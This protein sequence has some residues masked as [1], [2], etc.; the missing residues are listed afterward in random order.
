[1]IYLDTHIVVWLYAGEIERLSLKAK[2]A[3][4]QNALH[5]SPMVILELQYLHEIKRITLTA[6]TIIKDLESRIG[7]SICNMQFIDVINEAK[8]Y[9]WTRDPFDR[10][11]VANAALHNT[12]LISKDNIIK[13]HYS[14][15]IW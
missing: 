3:I 6:D 12:S 14:L 2:A 11:I 8:N 1:M 10:V 5:I 7:L 15:T 4:Q 9:Q 13:E